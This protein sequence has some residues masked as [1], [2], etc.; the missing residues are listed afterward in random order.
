VQ[1]YA[2]SGKRIFESI[3]VLI[4]WSLRAHTQGQIHMAKM[5]TA[6][7]TAKPTDKEEDSFNAAMRLILRKT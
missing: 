1:E 7:K 4:Y 5:N 2:V 3:L 6:S